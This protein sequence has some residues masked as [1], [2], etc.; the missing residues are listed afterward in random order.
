MCTAVIAVFLGPF[1]AYKIGLKRIYSSA[2]SNNRQEWINQ[3]RSHV[4]DL[5]GL[6]AVLVTQTPTSPDKTENLTSQIESHRVHIN[7]LLNPEKE[8]QSNISKVT[9]E[10][11]F[12][13]IDGKLTNK[14]SYEDSKNKLVELVRQLVRDEWLKVKALE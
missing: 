10:I 1:L 4:S 14:K 5:L 8:L 2:V 7:L 13:I 6:T 9:N 11:V 3:I 12:M